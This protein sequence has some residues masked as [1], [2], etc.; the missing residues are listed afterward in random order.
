MAEL[1]TVSF[2][3]G[4]GWYVLFSSVQFPTEPEPRRVRFNRTYQG[5]RFM[6]EAQAQQCLTLIRQRSMSQ[7]LCE[8]LAEY[9]PETPVGMLVEARWVKE[10]L[11]TKKAELERKEISQD[12]Y[13]ELEAYPRR[14][15]LRFFAEVAASRI[16]N[17]L[18][19][20]WLDWIKQTYPHLGQSSL[21]HVVTDFGAFC[22]YLERVGCLLHRPKMPAIKVPKK[23][24]TVPDR[25]SLERILDCMP[26]EERGLWMGR[27]YAGLRPAES[28]R[29]DVRDYHEGVLHIRPEICK[30]GE[31]RWLPL[32]DVA[33]ELVA[34]IE[35]N[36]K[37][38]SPWEPLFP[39]PVGRRRGRAVKITDRRWRP[40][41]ERRVW[42]AALDAAGFQHVAPNLGGRH[43]FI[44]RE[45]T[46]LQTD[47]LAV[48]DFVGHASLETTMKY[49]HADSRR[50][51]RRMRPVSAIKKEDQ[52]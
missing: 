50:L 41:S 6:D 40:T 42:V 39:A 32:G 26:E 9:M 28:R 46:V 38:A 34:W 51:A 45:M 7:P 37:G 33:P 29:V 4:R 11:P 24:R 30:T 8:I 49:T 35:R 14:G 36:R 21:R 18:V 23:A 43:H 10:F 12:R 5:G 15:Y 17:P 20:L 48:R 22:S 16:T 31:E 47:P 2:E 27:A 25:E 19:Q 44:T 13:R 52:A 3:K 1:G